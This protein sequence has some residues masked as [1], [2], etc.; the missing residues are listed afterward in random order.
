MKLFN[1]I[2][3]ITG[4]MWLNSILSLAQCFPDSSASWC[5]FSLN[6]SDIVYTR[7]IMGAEPDTAALG[8]IYKRIDEYNDAQG[9][10][11]WQFV[12]R[13]YVRSDSIGKGYVMLL[14]SMQEYLAADVSAVAGDTVDNVLTAD[15]WGYGQTYWLKS[16]IVDSVV[17]YSNNGVTV[18]RQFVHAAQ[19]EPSYPTS[20]EIFWQAG[21][22][23]SYGPL[24]LLDVVGAFQVLDCL[25]QQD[26]YVCSMNF[27]YPG[28][29][30]IPCDCPLESPL[31][32][33]DRTVVGQLWASPNPSTGLF[34]LN[35]GARSVI[36]F[37]ALGSRLLTTNTPRID[38]SD[39]PPGMYHALVRSDAGV[40]HLRL[41][42]QR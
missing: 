8:K 26:T 31:G 12:R 42:V 33:Q 22:G 17:S 37:D 1:P 14:D 21:M 6:S 20:Y 19:W 23:N 24:L 35:A 25:R 39:R 34:L 29:P 41:L 13:Y 38:L 4:L 36:V 7:M 40:G 2:R 30:G 27:A 16:V 5:F 9:V 32:V 3:G 10:D 28:L 15:S 11:S 18:T